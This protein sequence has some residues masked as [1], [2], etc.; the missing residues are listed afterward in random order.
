VDQRE[1]EGVLAH[2]LAHIKHRDMLV[3]TVAATMAAAISHIA[4]MLMWVGSR[5]DDGQSPVGGLAMMILAPI[6][7]GLIQM[8]ISRSRE[9]EAD[10][11]GAEI[12]GQPLALASALRK[13][14]AYARRTPMR[15]EP[16]AASLA[17]VNPL[18]AHG[19]GVLKLFSTHPPT[20]ERVR[21]LEELARRA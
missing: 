1:L 19:G 10:R 3:S 15:V 18:A 4:W 6:A 2:E 21:K 9:F 17:Q 5:D 14:D 16:A 7:A 8:A 12:S 11:G 13:L 20:E